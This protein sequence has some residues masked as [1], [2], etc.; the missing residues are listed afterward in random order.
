MH[1]RP[2]GHEAGGVGERDHLDHRLRPVDELDEHARVHVAGA[3]L[4]LVILG[5]GLEV[6]RV[7]LALAG[8]DD[9][10]SE[11]ACECDE[12]DRR[13]RLVTRRA[14]VD[15]ARAVGLAP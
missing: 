8:G 4:L 6:E 14:G 2:V 11:G 7:V 12:L 15:D 3:R 1:A 5:H 10:H 13:G 9:R